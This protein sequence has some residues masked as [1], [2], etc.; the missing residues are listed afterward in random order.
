L[1]TI[2]YDFL[3]SYLLNPASILARYAQLLHEL[4]AGLNGWA[5]HPGLDNSELLALEP[6]GHHERQSFH[7]AK[8]V[9]RTFDLPDVRFLVVY[10]P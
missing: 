5:V 10:Q 6:A 7:H 2:D 1:P 4:P 3:D 8:L 9:D